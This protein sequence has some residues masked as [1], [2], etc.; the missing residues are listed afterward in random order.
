MNETAKR[1]FAIRQPRV[2]DA[3][4]GHDVVCDVFLSEGRIL[5]LGQ[6]PSGFEPDVELDANGRW[7]I[8]GVVDLSARLREPGEAHKATIASECRAAAASGIT[9]LCVPP[10]SDPV[11]DTPA[12]VDWITRRAE[13]LGL[14]QV[15]VLGGLTQGLDGRHMAAMAA[16]RQGGC[17][18]VSNARRPLASAGIL[19]K[20]LEYASS[21]DLVTFLHPL[22]ESLAGSGCAHEGPVATRLGLPGIPEA[23][24]TA[25]LAK[26]LALV[27]QTGARV[28]FCR[29]S[30]ARS[31]EL[32]AAARQ[33]GLPVSADVA[34][35]QLFLTDGDI[36]DF[37][38][39]YHVDPPLR[40]RADREGLRAAVREGIIDA[41][42]SDH[43]PHEA[44]AKT[45]PF[46]LT[47]PGIS[48]LET[49]LPLGLRLVR[50][51]V[52]S[53]LELVA[54]LCEAPAR[55]L[56]LEAGTL[57][58]GETADL[59]LVDPD[60]TWTLHIE[61]LLSAG[62]NTPFT[63]QAFPGRATHTWIA[64]RLVHGSA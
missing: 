21:F 53:P 52:L 2:L 6:T 11:V 36:A 64:G 45:D 26:E 32:I 33:R 1:S 13:A 30:T 54:R 39:Q 20:L 42:C 63:G 18:G 28:H 37:N 31:V 61:D 14:T 24:E 43:Q 19:R 3:R 46:P 48:S 23:A 41:I 59:C 57:Q 62:R 58:P 49:L 15:R 17:V 12:V 25:A 34:A 4:T 47:A 27:E 60:A 22:D 10:D 9:T 44:D 40:S 38:S 56:G 55:I 29:L 16:L 5:A 35:H 51:D 50:E 7:L 8:P